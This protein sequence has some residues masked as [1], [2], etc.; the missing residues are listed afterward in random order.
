MGS[1]RVLGTLVKSTGSRPDQADRAV[2][3]AASGWRPLDIRDR[4]DWET[5]VCSLTAF[6][7]VFSGCDSGVQGS[8]ERRE[9]ETGCVESLGV[10]L[11]LPGCVQ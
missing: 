4:V 2:R 5:P 9:V 8:V 1:R 3:L 11:A 10:S 7:V 6:H